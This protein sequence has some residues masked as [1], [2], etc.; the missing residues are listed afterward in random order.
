MFKHTKRPGIRGL[1]GWIFTWILL[2]LVLVCVGGWLM[3]SYYTSRPP[4]EEMTQAQDAI[5]AA[6][7]S[8]ANVYATE[9]FKAATDAL[10]DAGVVVGD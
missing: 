7:A 6:Q 9:D 1:Y 10:A 3:W 8:V 2:L 5:L 4:T